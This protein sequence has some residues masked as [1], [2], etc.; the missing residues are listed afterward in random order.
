MDSPFHRICRFGRPATDVLAGKQQ[1]IAAGTS[2]PAVRV[3]IA[4]EKPWN[5]SPL[6]GKVPK[7]ESLAERP[8]VYASG[9][10]YSYVDIL[11]DGVLSLYPQERISYRMEK[12]V[13]EGGA[14]DLSA[15]RVNGFPACP[16]S[17]NWGTPEEVP[18][19]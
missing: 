13:M 4:A 5:L 14:Y 16:R 15:C 8:L 18:T 17:S 9:A 6:W 12:F 3:R 2:N 1:Q 7:K 19:L 10:V 11:A